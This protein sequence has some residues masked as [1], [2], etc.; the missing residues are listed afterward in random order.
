MP[1]S[2]CLAMPTS[3]LNNGAYFVKIL[4]AE[5][6]LVQLINLPV[7]STIFVFTRTQVW[8]MGNALACGLVR[9]RLSFF[10]FPVLPLLLFSMS[11]NAAGS[12]F[13]SDVQRKSTEKNFM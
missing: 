7:I 3:R 2:S 8:K 6:W 12:D 13:F 5:R 11:G 9:P 4:C 10:V 1:G